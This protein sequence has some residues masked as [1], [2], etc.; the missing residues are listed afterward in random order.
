MVILRNVPLSAYSTMR[1]GGKAAYLAEVTDKAEIDEGVRWADGRGLPVLMIG[2]GSNVIWQDSGFEGLVLV[3]KLLGFDIFDEDDENLY[4]TVGAGENWDS[5]VER[6]VNLGCSGIEELSLIPGSAGATPVQNV[7]AYGRELKDTLTTVEA[8]DRQSKKFVTIA[9][10]D[11]DFGYR[12]SRFNGKDKGRYFIS[13]LT[14]HLLKQPPQQPFY[15]SVASYFKDHGIT[16]FTAQTVRDAVI[17]IRS[18]KLPDPNIVANNG[19][20]FYN[21][22]IDQQQQQRL[23]VDFPDMVYWPTDDNKVKVSAAWLLEKAGFKDMHDTETGMSTWPKQPL[24]LVNE[25]ATSTANLLQFKQKILDKVKA[26]FQI[27]LV[28]E[29]EVL[30]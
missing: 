22:I 21:P 18:A 30:P 25:H 15:E 11:C 9:G 17:A 4:V 8:Y 7:G 20:F 6:V 24:I 29:P 27:E 5:V 12:K 1:L 3:N 16:T 14:L 23:L 10:A 26:M 13:Y 2:T 28:Q 19:S